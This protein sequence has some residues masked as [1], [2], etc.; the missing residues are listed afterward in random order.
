M[1]NRAYFEEEMARLEGS[2][3]YP[4]SIISCDLDGLKQI[5]DQ[6]GHDAGDRA[7][8]GAAKV[9][10]GH[11]FRK[12]DVVARIGGGEFIVILPKVDLDENRSI[13]DRIDLGL[14]QF[15]NSLIDDDL[16][17]PISLSLGHAV[18]QEGGSLAEG[19]KEADQAMY[20]NKQKKKLNQ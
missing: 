10:S 7:I 6:F 8:K 9:L 1:Y 11:T 5:N 12:E 4:V 14:S 16:Y 13:L 19:Y 2:R 3:Q 15:N 17:R 18:I 20:S